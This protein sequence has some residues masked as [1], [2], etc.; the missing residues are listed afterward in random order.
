MSTAEHSVFRS[1]HALGIGLALG[2][3]IALSVGGPLI[4]MIEQA[5]GWTVM[6]YRGLTFTAT[7]F[8]IICWRSR[9]QCIE[10][11]RSIGWPGLAIAL[12]LGVGL[13]TYLFAMIHTTVANVTFVVGSSPL[14]TAFLAWIILGERLSARSWAILICALGG[15][16]LMVAEGLAAGRV[17]GNV[18]AIATTLTF[19][20]FVILLRVSRAFDMLAATSLAGLVAAAISAYMATTL[21]ITAHDLVI[22][23]LLGSVQVGLGFTFITYASRHIPAAEVTLLSLSETILGPIWAWLVIGEMPSGWTLLGGA[24]VLFCVA[25]FASLALRRGAGSHTVNPAD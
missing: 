7:L 13:I 16:G 2:G 25:L 17:L 11:Y 14:V 5:D 21:S 3:G 15:I 9:G 6:F 10:R 20:S 12:C 23:L 18:V 19:A 1:S 22:A 24:V 4:K 8:L